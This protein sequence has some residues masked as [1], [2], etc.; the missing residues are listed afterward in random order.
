M[1]RIETVAADVEARVDSGQLWQLD[2]ARST[3]PTATAP[4]APTASP[5]PTKAFSF[6]YVVSG[7]KG[8]DQRAATRTGTHDPRLVG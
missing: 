8:G 6:A 3:A 4:A 1:N 5:A 7:R 2:S